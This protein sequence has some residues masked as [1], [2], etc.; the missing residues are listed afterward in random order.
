MNSMMIFAGFAGTLLAF[1]ALNW[2]F[3]RSTVRVQPYRTTLLLRFGK[4][5]EELREPGLY[6]RPTLLVPGYRS[7]EVSRQLD[8]E[9]LRELHVTDRD[10]TTL[11]VDLW[12]ECRVED[13]KRSVFA[14]ESWRDAIRNSLLHSLTDAT[15]SR[16]LDSV[17]RNREALAGEMLDAIRADAESW[18]VRVEQLWI[19]DVRI[20]PE[21]AKQFFDR[22]AARLEMEKSRVEEQGR[23]EIQLH[24]AETER[25]VA[26]M[27]AQARAMHPLA[28][29]RAYSRI[30]ENS[31]V[32]EAYQELYRLSLIQPNSTVTF[33]GFKPG[34][35]RAM[36]AVMIPEG[37]SG[38]SG[39]R[40]A[41]LKDET[42]AS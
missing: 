24:Q 18:G 15:A 26:V 12:I 17:I 25:E 10:G 37:E 29:G 7:I 30:N 32:F 2:L 31:T 6:F 22:V 33:V 23:I 8:F 1:A 16:R 38:H 11:R 36:D 5:I 28:I 13:A 19:Q 9:T 40:L 34:D 35:I 4:C 21:I 42:N 39:K 41:A 14:V 3:L 27:H 20:L